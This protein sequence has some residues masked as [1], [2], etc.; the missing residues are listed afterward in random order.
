MYR[1]LVKKQIYIDILQ[2]TMSRKKY[3]TWKVGSI[4]LNKQEAYV[5]T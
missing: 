5:L 3:L 2:V 1:Y 4:L